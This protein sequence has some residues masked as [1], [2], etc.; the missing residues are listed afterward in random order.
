[1]TKKIRLALVSSSLL[2]MVTFVDSGSVAAAPSH[3]F[4]IFECAFRKPA[5]SGYVTVWGYQ[6]STGATENLRVGPMNHFLPQPFDRGQ[7]VTFAAERHDNVAIIDWN[8]TTALKWK[9]GNTT[10][11]AATTPACRTNPVPL[12]GG[13]LTRAVTLSALAALAF[14]LS[15]HLNRRRK[16]RQR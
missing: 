8:G 1:M 13:R 16:V 2:M 4:P 7:P 12:L 5:G 9:I 15:V 10:V 11:A 14:G 3:T 6:N